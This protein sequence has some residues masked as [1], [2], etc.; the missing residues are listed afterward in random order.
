MSDRIALR[1]SE[2]WAIFFDPQQWIL[3]SA[4][5]LRSERKWQPVAY[6]GSTKATLARVTR[7]IGA[8]VTPAAQ[9]VLDTWPE[10]FLDWRDR[11]I[12]E[13]RAA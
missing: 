10:R 8:D 11:R 12:A 3:C 1:L 7:E 9:A 6:V 4:R 5:N 13:R 2:K